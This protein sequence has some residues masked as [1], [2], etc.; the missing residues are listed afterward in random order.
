MKSLA[1]MHRNDTRF[2]V[3]D[4]SP[5]L[6]VFSHYELGNTISPFL[7]LDHIGPGL[8]QPS[9][10]RKGVHEHPH[11]GFETVTIVYAG[12]IEHRDSTGAGGIIR[13]GDVQWMTAAAGILHEEFFSDAFTQRGGRFELVQL[14]VNLPAA[15]KMSAPGYQSLVSTAIPIIELPADGGSVRVIAGHFNE[16]AGPAR[17]HTRMSILDVQ[18]RA[19]HEVTFKTEA[20]DTALVFL[21]SGSLQFLPDERLEADGLAVMSSRERDFVVTAIENSQLLVLIGEPLNEPINAHGPFVMNS[22]NE[23]LQGFEDLKGGRFG[24]LPDETLSHH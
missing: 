11:R 2:A 20:G 18:I 5:V 1:F 9:S 4:F 19:G 15:S 22:Y 12:E 13:A 14:W 7:L 16:T 3:G 21:R 8:L 23:V 6:S 17:T 24:L 10:Q